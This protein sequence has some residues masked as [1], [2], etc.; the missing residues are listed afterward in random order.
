M[1]EI[2]KKKQFLDIELFDYFFVLKKRI[3]WIILITLALSIASFGL[4]FLFPKKWR[5]DCILSPSKFLV[6]T[7]LGEFHEVIVTSPDQI[8]N[9]INR[10]SYNSLIASQ[11]NIDLLKMPRIRASAIEGTNL[12]YI[13]LIT[14]DV[15]FGQKILN[16][17]HKHLEYLL[18]RKA[19]IEMKNIF[20]DIEIKKNQINEKLINIKA[21]ENQIEMKKIL[22]KNKDNAIVDIE[23]KIQM[24][25]NQIL[26]KTADISIKEI[27]KARLEKEIEADKNKLKISEDKIE[28]LRK[29]MEAVK[30]RIDELDELQKKALAEKRGAGDSIA[31]LLYSNEI[32][33]NLRY[34]SSLN[35]KLSDE[36]INQESIKLSINDKQE[37]LKQID[38]NISQIRA[39]Q[40]SLNAEINIYLSDINKIKNEKEQI[41]SEIQSIRNDIEKIKN[42]IHY[43]EIEIN[44]LH[45]K[46]NR[47]DYAELIKKPTPSLKPVSPRRKIIV[48]STAILSFFL[49]AIVSFFIEYSQR[50]NNAKK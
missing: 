47:I 28:S 17:L 3:W 1:N 5:V 44:L 37:R 48:L 32:Q 41:L 7:Q 40:D 49:L 15:E 50:L 42:S 18:N 38:A 6:Q 9:E 19:D 24:K 4:S 25:R 36:K 35:E 10:E 11:L 29:E 21:A 30:S 13:Y 33:Q 22:L 26:E 39:Q 23:N 46:K 14:S 20:T 2:N 43:I 31:L 45:D 8:A 27:E 16:T 34:Y 12:V